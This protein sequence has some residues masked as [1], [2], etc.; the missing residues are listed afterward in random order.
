MLFRSCSFTFEAAL[1]EGGIAISHID[2][3]TN[4]PMYRTSVRSE[5]AGSISG[6]LV[7]SMLP[8]PAAQVADAVRITSRYPSV[9]GAPV[10]V[11]HPEELGIADLGNPDYGD[12]VELGEEYV[13]VFWASGLTPQVAVMAA[14]PSLVIGQAPGH[15]LITDA[16]DSSYLV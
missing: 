2:K 8:I 11:G 10:H 3:G 13:P 6:P 14:T 5:P 1:Q 12:P 4:V 9:H 15:L 7:V 16:R